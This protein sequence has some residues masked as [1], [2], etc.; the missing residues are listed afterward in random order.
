MLEQ[1]GAYVVDGATVNLC[2]AEADWE[3]LAQDDQVVRLVVGGDEGMECG[4]ARDHV[5]LFEGLADV[6]SPS[7]WDWSGW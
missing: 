2:G 1:V 4:G 5:C 7:F 3:S 6:G